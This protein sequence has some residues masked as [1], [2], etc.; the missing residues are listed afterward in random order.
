MKVLHSWLYCLVMLPLLVAC[1][2]RSARRLEVPEAMSPPSGIPADVLDE[3]NS[4]QPKTSVIMDSPEFKFDGFEDGVQFTRFVENGHHCIRNMLYGWTKCFKDRPGRMRTDDQ[5]DRYVVVLYGASFDESFI[6]S[7]YHPKLIILDFKTGKELAIVKRPGR[8]SE[9][10]D[11][12]YMHVLAVRGD[13]LYY[14]IA[15]CC[16]QSLPAE[17]T[18]GVIAVALP[19]SQE[20]E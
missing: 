20:R 4:I 2:E 8:A 14:Q 3:L 15:P 1:T 11:S 7:A 10:D 18:T 13:K 16:R 5:N 9:S 12:W 6:A 17:R 19:T